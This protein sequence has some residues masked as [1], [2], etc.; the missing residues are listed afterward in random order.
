MK[1][2][3]IISSGGMYGA[4][5][6][7]LTLSRIMNT[8]PHQSVLGVFS[9]SARPNLQLYEAATA[10]NIE[11][12]LISC[13]GQ[14][15][16]SV[17]A[18]IR[19]LVQQI[20]AD[21]VHAHGY[22][23]DIYLYLAMRGRSTATISTCHTWYDNDLALRIYGLLDRFALKS[24][25]GI[26]AVSKEV[27]QRL[28]D[29]GVSRDRIRLIRNGIDLRSF[30]SS[31]GSAQPETNRP[32]KVGLVGRLSPEK[33]VDVFLRAAAEVLIELPSTRFV[34][35]GD[36]PDHIQLQTLINELHIEHA[37]Y[38]HGRE[39]DM[40]SFY[41]SL[42][43]MVSSS[44][45]EGLPMALLEGMASGLP[46]VATA[47]GAVPTVVQ[48]GQTGLLV[49]PEDNK[50]LAA[51]ILKLLRDPQTRQAYGHAARELVADQYSAERMTADYLQLYEHV[52]KPPNQ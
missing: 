1:V 9:N 13:T 4:E 30:S 7:I 5:A 34:V 19:K 47:V 35:V 14:L 48:N 29:A 44:R 18:A 33:G 41:R 27:E 52:L 8:G 49:P 15:D 25:A 12:H 21:I 24:Y 32:L 45:Q 50:E 23:A 26:V 3:H 31:D 43:L 37:A 11:A 16:R 36:G 51:A 20:G 46:L 38:L 40:P 28:L 42:D 6:V 2:L 22:K 39:E 10:E 17:P